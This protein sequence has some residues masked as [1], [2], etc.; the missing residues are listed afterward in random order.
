MALYKVKRTGVTWD[1]TDP[2]T[3]K[4]VKE[5]PLAYEPVAEESK[6]TKKEAA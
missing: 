3:L 6:K 5:D 1:V 4:R 2:I